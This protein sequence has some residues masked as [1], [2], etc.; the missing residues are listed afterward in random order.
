MVGLF[1][2]LMLGWAGQANAQGPPN[3]AYVGFERDYPTFERL[4][5]NGTPVAGKVA[6]IAKWSGVP[7]GTTNNQIK[8]EVLA[9]TN[10]AWAP[11]GTELITTGHSS[12]GVD[13]RQV[14]S[15]PSNTTV[16][17]RLSLLNGAN[18]KLVSNDSA[19]VAVP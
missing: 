3:T 11:N 16:K 2:A 19:G 12:G 14:L 18:Q 5:P 10:G 4:P 1:L 17:I 8:Y 7:A 13:D 15:A 6:I 9:N